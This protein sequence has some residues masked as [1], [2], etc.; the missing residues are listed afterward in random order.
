MGQ[1]REFNLKKPEKREEIQSERKGEM[2]EI[3]AN[4]LYIFR[5]GKLNNK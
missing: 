2:K 3:Y 1:M 5:I 4:L